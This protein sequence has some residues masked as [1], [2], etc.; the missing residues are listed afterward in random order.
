MWPPAEYTN[1][2]RTV[3]PASSKMLLRSPCPSLECSCNFAS[4][5]RTRDDTRVG[6]QP[7]LLALVMGVVEVALR[8]RSGRACVSTRTLM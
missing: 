7:Q 2:R 3:A 4:S 6:A 8:T 1:T 5:A